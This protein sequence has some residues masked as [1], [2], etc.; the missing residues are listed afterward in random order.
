MIFNTV[1]TIID[2]TITQKD[3]FLHFGSSIAVSVNVTWSRLF[4]LRLQMDNRF[5]LSVAFCHA[6]ERFLLKRVVVHEDKTYSQTKSTTPIP[7]EYS[8][9]KADHQGQ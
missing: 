2:T 8:K 4:R 3:D 9:Q 6:I 5:E 7:A 1:N